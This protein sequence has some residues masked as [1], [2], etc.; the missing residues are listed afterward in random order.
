MNYILAYNF[1]LQQLYYLPET[2]KGIAFNKR[3]L[4]I[5]NSII[6]NPLSQGFFYMRAASGIVSFTSFLERKYGNTR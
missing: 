4:F 5:L 1:D 3:K 2:K 6:F